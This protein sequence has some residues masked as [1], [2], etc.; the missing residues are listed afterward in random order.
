MNKLAIGGVIGVIVLGAVAVYFFN[1]SQNSNSSNQQPADAVPI[2]RPAV[3]AK[4]NT[5]SVMTPE[6]RA[7]AEV[8]ERL[9][10]A[11]ASSTA[12]TTASTTLEAEVEVENENQEEL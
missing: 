1:Q 11:E 6:E 3:Q 10:A 12:S 9:A 7:A 2:T 8:Q 5:F 4:P